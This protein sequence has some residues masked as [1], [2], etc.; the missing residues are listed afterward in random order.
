MLNLKVLIVSTQLP[1]VKGGAEILENNLK[2]AL[3][4]KGHDAEITKIPFTGNTPKG[5]VE[6]ILATRLLDLTLSA[7]TN[8]DLLVSLK[9]P[10]YCVKHPNK[11]TWVLH[12][13]R[14]VYDLWGTPYQHIPSDAEGLR[15]RQ[16]IK[17]CDNQFLPESKKIFTL[18][19]NV[20]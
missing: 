5:I 8:I 17:N 19:K 15:V 14:D 9:F 2:K 3:E 16:I 11:V 12:Q 7:G 13:H 1:F 4:E 20:T 18:S 10:A 6:Q